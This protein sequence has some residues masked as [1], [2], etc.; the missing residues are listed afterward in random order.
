MGKITCARCHFLI[1][2][3]CEIKDGVAAP[4]AFARDV[5]RQVA[6]GVEG[7]DEPFPHAG[8]N[9]TLADPSLLE[10][11]EINLCSSDWE[12]PNG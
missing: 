5:L 1:H 8:D 2:A 7:K 3:L 11:G 10:G 4:R 6:M 9:F 12:R